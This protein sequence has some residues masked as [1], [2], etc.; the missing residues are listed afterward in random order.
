MEMSN[1]EIQQLIE[2]IKEVGLDNAAEVWG[3]SIDEIVDIYPVDEYLTDTGQFPYP[4]DSGVEAFTPDSSKIEEW[5][6]GGVQSV[7]SP[8]DPAIEQG[9]ASV[10][11]WMN[12]QGLPPWLAATVLAIGTK[13]KSIKGGKGGM[14]TPRK[15]KGNQL[16]DKRGTRSGQ[17]VGPKKGDTVNAKTQAKSQQHM[18]KKYGDANKNTNQM[19]KVDS[20]GGPLAKTNNG[21]TRRFGLTRKNELKTA[22]GLTAGLVANRML[23]GNRNAQGDF[24]TADDGVIYDDPK[25]APIDTEG[26]QFG[27][28]KQEGQNFW[29]VNNDDPYWDTHVMGTGDAWSDADAKKEVKE[30]N[31]D[32]SNWF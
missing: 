11:D 19:Q 4:E 18:Q 10:A 7:L 6:K 14:F 29:T 22:A 8:F 12:E 20:K 3:M 26:N 21:E 1:D 28:H 32:W 16:T 31:I 27:Y 24:I 15:N 17:V 23:N 25:L 13:G 2:T 30:L 9:A 5:E